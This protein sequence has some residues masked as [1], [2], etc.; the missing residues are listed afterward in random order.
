MPVKRRD[1]S[2]VRPRGDLRA[3]LVAV[4]LAAGAGRR[5]GGAKLTASWRG[6]VLLDG[7]LA[8]AF[9]APVDRVV[10]VAG[11]DD[12]VGAVARTFAEALDATDRLQLVS[13]PDWA[14]GMAASLRAGL[15]ALAPDIRG[16]FIFL[17]DMP[18]IPH[19]LAARLAEALTAGVQAVQPLYRGAPGHPVLLGAELFAA[20][21]GLG[22][23][24][25]AQP[26][27]QA[28]GVNVV[29]LEVDA[30]GVNLDVDTRDALAALVEGR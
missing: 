26:L 16:A 22:G 6:G 15:Q 18:Q 29:R 28:A 21:T 24:R 13:A 10:V 7:A 30:P 19:G 20:A 4:V 14:S 1:A 9:A 2:L 11:A 12:K 27:L 23:D 25:G 8:A 17:G 5:F 3:G